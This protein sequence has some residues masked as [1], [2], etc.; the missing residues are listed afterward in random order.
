MPGIE[1]DLEN[2]YEQLLRADLTANGHK[3]KTTDKIHD[4]MR[5]SINYAKRQI[6]PI[7]WKIRVSKQLAQG[8]FCA[9]TQ[10]G[11]SELQ[12]EAALGHNLNPRLSRSMKKFDYNDLLFNDWGFHHFHLGTAIEG[13]G[14]KERTDDLLFVVAREDTLY[15]IDVLPHKGSFSSVSLLKIVHENWPEIISHYKLNVLGVSPNLNDDEIAEARKHGI[16]VMIDVGGAVYA[17][18]G[19]GITTA[20]TNPLHTMQADFLLKTLRNVEAD[21]KTREQE[22]RHDISVSGAVC[23]ETLQLKLVTISGKTLTIE[24]LSSKAIFEFNLK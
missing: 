14:F 19:G 10:S 8:K 4:L 20:G 1:I 23:P 6:L 22:L 24:E 7:K 13:D 11:I 17:P 18:P 5:K 3:I 16:M 21:I 9:S 2:D 12:K 15:L